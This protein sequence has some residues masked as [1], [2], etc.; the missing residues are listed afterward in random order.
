MD[1][2]RHS[3]QLNE[4]RSITARARHAI[5]VVRARVV[6]DWPTSS[7]PR[8]QARSYESGHCKARRRPAKNRTRC[9]AHHL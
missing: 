9:E 3:D 6:P 4:V 7:G 2:W 8:I 5:I 1:S